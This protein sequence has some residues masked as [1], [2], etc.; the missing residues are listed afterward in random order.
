LLEGR[1]I[2]VLMLSEVLKDDDFRND[3]EFYSSSHLQVINILSKSKHQTIK[4]TIFRGSQPIYSDR[5]ILVVKSSQIS[6]GFPKTDSQEFV[7][8][9][10]AI[11]NI[12]SV[13]IFNDVLVNG[14]GKGTLGRCSIYLGQ[15]K[16]FADGH[17]TIFRT[18]EVLP[19]FLYAFLN[20]KYGQ[21]Q[22]EAR[23]RGSSGQLEIYPKDF[24]KMLIP[25]FSILFQ[26]KIEDVV[27]QAH[28]YS[29]Q[30]KTLYTEA[31]N[32]LLESLGLKDIEWEQANVNTNVKTFSQSFLTS[33]RLDAEYYQT[34]Y[35]VLESKCYQNAHYVKTVKDIQLHNS[36]GLQPDYVENGDLDVINSRHILET[37][38]DYKNFEKTSLDNWVLQAKA[39]VFKNDILI[40]TT[41]ANIGRT[42]VY[43]SDEKAL[44]SNHVNILRIKDEDPIYI[45]FVLN[46]KIG[47]L[48]TEQLSA[49]SAQQELYPKDIDNFY[50]PFTEKSTQTAIS[51]K[52][53]SS[54]ALKT[55]SEQLLALAKTAVEV[56]IEQGEAAALALL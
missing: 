55:E 16:L 18:L 7:S 39:R 33:G 13:I 14:T 12:S 45:A 26:T 20:T 29:E 5:G 21:T 40:Y 24:A 10:F 38:L 15:S 25:T 8:E 49:G 1:E 22:I 41:G 56:A 35:E 3:A 6:K 50:I 46:S 36:R 37:S 17:V 2:S 31:E 44:A 43:L 19:A 27:K 48:Q 51:S 30:S 23:Q 53:Q 42:Q 28:F 9:Q 47:R 34:K 4:G 54:F 11:Q 52:I 32:L